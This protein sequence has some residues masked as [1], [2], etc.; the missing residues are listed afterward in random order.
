MQKC[1]WEADPK[2]IRGQLSQV[3]YCSY[4][5]TEWVKTSF[6]T[7][8]KVLER[9]A[10]PARLS[11]GCRDSRRQSHIWSVQDSCSS[12]AVKLLKCCVSGARLNHHRQSGHRDEK[13]YSKDKIPP[14]RRKHI[15]VGRGI[16]SSLAHQGCINK[17]CFQEIKGHWSFWQIS[18]T[19]RWRRIF[20]KLSK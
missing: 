1:K 7:Y 8:R 16:Q 12:E 11:F 20:H 9:L 2:Q 14:I 13:Q 19:E 4:F 3:L 17:A 10:E 18:P 15:H 5:Y 6:N